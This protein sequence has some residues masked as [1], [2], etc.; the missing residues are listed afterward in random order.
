MFKVYRKW[1]IHSFSK[2]PGFIIVHGYK[3]NGDLEFLKSYIE[4]TGNTRV[5][6]AKTKEEL[7]E[8]LRSNRVIVMPLLVENGNIDLE[9]FRLSCGLERYDMDRITFLYMDQ[10]KREIIVK[11]DMIAEP[12]PFPILEYIRGAYGEALKI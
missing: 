1:N 6:L 11:S 2:D 4:S 7:Y 3:G 8:K 10:A 9:F 12:K 5:V